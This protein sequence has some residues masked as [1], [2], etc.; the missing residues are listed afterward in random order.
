M[1]NEYCEGLVKRSVASA[2]HEMEAFQSPL[3]HS[4]ADDG[5]IALSAHTCPGLFPVTT[6]ANIMSLSAV[7]SLFASIGFFPV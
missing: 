5:F 4:M 7:S 2:P 6:P 3:D 1:I